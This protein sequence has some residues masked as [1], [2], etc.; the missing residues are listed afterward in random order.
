VWLKANS[1]QNSWAGIIS[2]TD[3]TGSTNHWT[4]QFN[5]NNPRELI[6]HHPYD[7]WDT[8]I[9][10]NDI[11]GQW[12]HITVTRNGSTM[13]SYLDGSPEETGFVAVPGSGMGHLN[14]GV[15][16]M[17][18]SAYAYGGFIDDVR[19]Y[20][21]ALDVND[22]N[23]VMNGLEV[24]SGLI[25]RWKLD[26]DGQ[27]EIIVTAAPAKTAIWCWSVSGERQKWAQAAG[28]FYKVIRRN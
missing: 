8:G 21:Q 5:N 20:N 6:I 15:N 12:H 23:D 4:L 28:A 19:I 24:S 18:S 11:A 17:A 2:K 7:T 27:R 14:I 16:R 1:S 10:I 13:K 25:A 26:E 9:T 3:P 22:V